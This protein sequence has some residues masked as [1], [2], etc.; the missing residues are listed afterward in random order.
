M[1]TEFNTNGNVCRTRWGKAIVS[2]PA[3]EYT[4]GKDVVCHRSHV[5]EAIAGYS[6]GVTKEAQVIAVKVF[7]GPTEREKEQ[8]KK[9]GAGTSNIIKDLEWSVTDAG[10]SIC[11]SAGDMSFGGPRSE[12]FNRGVRAAVYVGM[13]VT[14]ASG[15]GTADTPLEARRL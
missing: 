11:Q 13:T 6:C 8:H 3:K 7:P 2:G 4:S 5:A 15:N 14:V 12:A 1:S 9:K 10:N